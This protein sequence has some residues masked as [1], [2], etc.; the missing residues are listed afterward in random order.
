MQSYPG[1][2]PVFHNLVH[3]VLKRE[4]SQ[5][6]KKRIIARCPQLKVN[7]FGK[8]KQKRRLC[9]DAL[10]GLGKLE[11]FLLHTFIFGDVL[12]LKKQ[13]RYP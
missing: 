7:T 10:T 5:R 13:N 12:K 1:C 9:L 6:L 4:M 3:L 11:Y 8:P 2:F